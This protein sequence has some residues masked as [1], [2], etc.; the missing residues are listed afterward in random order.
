MASP[1]RAGPTRSIFMITVVDQ[2]R[3]WL[4]PSS[5]LAT[6]I[7]PQDGASMISS[8]TGSPTIHP[9]TRICLRPIRSLIRP[10]NR[11]ASAFVTPKV[12]MNERTAVRE[13]RRKSCSASSG[14]TARSMPTMP[15]TKALMTTSSVNCCQFA[16][17]PRRKRSAAW[18]TRGQLGVRSARPA[19][20]FRLPPASRRR[21]P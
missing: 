12:T 1:R 21:P 15:P 19:G 18:L 7:Q 6:T 16:R 8:G 2:H 9:A 10:A 3:P 13:V 11:F 5:T 14:S 4:M 17:R 20:L